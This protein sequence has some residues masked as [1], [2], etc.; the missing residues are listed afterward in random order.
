MNIAYITDLEEWRKGFKFYIPIKIRFSETDM[1]GHVNNVSP[2]IYFEEGRI[3]FFKK[4]G[5]FGGLEK[6]VETIPV[7]ADLQ[8][9]YHKQ[10]YFNHD[11][12]LYV[13]V[14]DIGTSSFDVHYMALNEQEEICLTGRGR[15]VQVNPV[16][17]KS[18]PLSEDTKAKLMTT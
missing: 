5:I 3:E 16:S 18:V 1:F 2:F 13:K 4:T 9:D 14:N 8:C 12:D 15:I 6:D 7:V 10:M 17:G 11:I